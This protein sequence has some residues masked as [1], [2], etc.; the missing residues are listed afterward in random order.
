MNRTPPK[1][2]LA[3]DL[4]ST[5][6]PRSDLQ[7]TKSALNELKDLTDRLSEFGSCWSNSESAHSDIPHEECNSS[8]EKK[9][10]KKKRKLQVTPDKD[11][12]LKKPN[13]NNK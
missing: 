11:S 3:E 8:K 6:S 12:F 9:K 10:R 4:L 13:L 1:G 7:K 5:N 2:S